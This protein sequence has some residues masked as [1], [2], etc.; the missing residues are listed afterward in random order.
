MKGPPMS[1]T[2]LLFVC[3]TLSFPSV[4]R[5]GL[6]YSGEDFAELPSRWRGFLLDQRALRATGFKP[7]PGVPASLFRTRYEQEAVRL[8]KLP[9]RSPDQSADLGALY[10]R[11]G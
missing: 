9:E 6:H 1:R 7:A 4:A 5:A 8:A 11:L 10:I 2:L 3:L